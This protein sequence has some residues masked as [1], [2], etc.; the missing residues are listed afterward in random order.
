MQRNVCN[1]F[2]T[3]KFYCDKIRVGPFRLRGNGD[4]KSDHRRL[5][6]ENREQEDKDRSCRF[7]V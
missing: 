7:F 5:K 4:A 3:L 2:W 1:G 6:G